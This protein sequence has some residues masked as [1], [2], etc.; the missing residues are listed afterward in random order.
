LIQRSSKESSSLFTLKSGEHNP[1]KGSRRMKTSTPRSKESRIVVT[2]EFSGKCPARERDGRCFCFS[3]RFPQTCQSCHVRIREGHCITKFG[4][5]WVHVHCPNEE[6]RG[7]IAIKS[8]FRQV[9][10]DNLLQDEPHAA[11]RTLTYGDSDSEEENPKK[12]PKR[13]HQ[14]H[15]SSSDDRGDD[16]EE[17]D[18]KHRTE[19]Q[20]NITRL[21]PSM[22]ITKMISLKLSTCR[23]T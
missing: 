2:P 18:S 16:E 3:A 1:S 9:R 4:S 10:Y 23:L 19:E 13:L 22:S 6:R 7:Q 21:V 11:K 20:Q 15:H 17:E 8:D 14:S 12:Q 5:G